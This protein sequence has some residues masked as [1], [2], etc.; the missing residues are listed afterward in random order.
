MRQLVGITGR[1]ALALLIAGAGTVLGVASSSAAGPTVV[2]SPTTGVSWGDT[3][4]V[5][6]SGYP[7]Q[8]AAYIT[9]CDPGTIGT[10]L[11][12]QADFGVGPACSG[13][14]E[15]RFD[16]GFNPNTNYGFINGANGSDTVVLTDGRASSSHC[17]TG[18]CDL[19]VFDHNCVDQAPG[20]QCTF[21]GQP[22]TFASAIP[23]T[24]IKGS[25]ATL[26]YRPAKL[27]AHYN[28][29]TCTDATASLTI[30]N[31]S[32]HTVQPTAGGNAIGAPLTPGA[33][34]SFC[35]TGT[36]RQTFTFGVQGSTNVL[37]VKAS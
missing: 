15:H 34:G 12:V 10:V 1:I 33:V 24:V 8:E 25:G 6:T 35:L 36:G 7:V 3:I 14:L 30:T 37:T 31:G 22:L 23:N 9:L 18:R 32:R 26:R 29:A 28:N 11:T 21:L 16:P 27:R 20:T 17:S 19:V 5:T 13:E 2:A 4:T